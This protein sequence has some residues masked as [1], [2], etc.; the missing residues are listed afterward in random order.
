LITPGGIFYKNYE[1]GNK[2]FRVGFSQVDD[3]QIREGVNILNEIL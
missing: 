1:E 3:E 2:Q